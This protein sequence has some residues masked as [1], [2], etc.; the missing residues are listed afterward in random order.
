[1][2][3]FSTCMELSILAMRV[4]ARLP[5]FYPYDLG[6]GLF[7]PYNQIIDPNSETAESSTSKLGD[8]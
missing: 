2:N 6:G 1:M 7:G 3:D 8:F 4:L 5:Y